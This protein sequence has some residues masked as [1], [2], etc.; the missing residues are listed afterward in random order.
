MRPPF[1]HK[2]FEEAAVVGRCL[3]SPARVWRCSFEVRLLLTVLFLAGVS[4]LAAAQSAAAQPV[5]APRRLALPLLPPLKPDGVLHS[6][7]GTM[8]GLIAASI[9]AQ[10]YPQ[11][12]IRRYPLLLPAIGASTALT[13]GI[14]K[15][16]LDSTG[17]GDPQWHDIMHTIL[18]GAVATAFIA[19]AGLAYDGR[20]ASMTNEAW[21]YG[22]VGITFA[23]PV[24]AGLL[25]EIE[26]YLE[27]RRSGK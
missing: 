17:F 7:A 6:L 22:S 14:A 18:G 9:A 4:E 3:G 15:E 16:V 26:L 8:S 27:K 12:T 23:V 21:L 13:A 25:R 2:R 5:R 20:R 11:S 24:A 19:A 10:A 1:P